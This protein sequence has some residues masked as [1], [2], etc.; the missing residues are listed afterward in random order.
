MRGMRVHRILSVP[1]SHMGTVRRP[2][3]CNHEHIPGKTIV[4]FSMK[5]FCWATTA[6]ILAAGSASAQTAQRCTSL[7]PGTV[8][9]RLHQTNGF[10]VVLRVM[11]DEARDANARPRDTVSVEAWQNKEP[12]GPMGIPPDG[13]GTGTLGPGDGLDITVRWNNGTV[14]SYTARARR[15]QHGFDLV[16]GRT[17]DVIHPSSQANWASKDKLACAD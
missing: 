9:Y 17:H 1:A 16:G 15:V 6:M 2:D 10:D 8:F 5:H 11:K 12:Q 3:S 14:G 4:T 13:T 7:R